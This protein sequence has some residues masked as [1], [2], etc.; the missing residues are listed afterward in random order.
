MTLRDMFTFEELT[1]AEV[2]TLGAISLVLIFVILPEKEVTISAT[3]IV[4]T[5]QFDEYPL[6]AWKDVDKKGDIVRIKYRVFDDKT[7]I[8]IYDMKGGVVH[9]QPFT[10]SPWEDGTPRDFTY[11]WTLYYTQDYGDDILPGEYEIRVCH[12]YDRNVALLTTITV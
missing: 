11:N 10:R 2:L 8:K 3:D 12:R 7:Y 6:I 9:K 4:S 1:L 5:E